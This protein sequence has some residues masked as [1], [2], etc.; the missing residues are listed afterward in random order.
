MSLKYY[1]VPNI[2]I[3]ATSY[4]LLYPNHTGHFIKSFIPKIPQLYAYLNFLWNHFFSIRNYKVV[5]ILTIRNAPF[6]HFVQTLN[7]LISKNRNIKTKLFP[8][9]LLAFISKFN[10][11]MLKYIVHSASFSQ[12]SPLT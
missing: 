10:F 12:H 8:L 6:P 4:Y 3:L 1:Q 9:H 2:N 11:E 7:K 5:N